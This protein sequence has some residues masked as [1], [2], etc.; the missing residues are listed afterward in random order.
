MASEFEKWK[1]S[2]IDEVDTESGLAICSCRNPEL[3]AE[4]VREHNLSI[5]IEELVSRLG[6]QGIAGSLIDTVHLN[7]ED[8]VNEKL[9]DQLERYFVLAT[10][11]R[12]KDGE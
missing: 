1:V 10:P 8:Y 4:I 7:S 6:W 3:A 9:V 12:G 5:K 2:R 11:Q